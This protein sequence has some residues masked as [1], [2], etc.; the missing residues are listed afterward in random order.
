MKTLLGVVFILIAPFTILYAA[1][2]VDLGTIG[3]D[4]KVT[5]LE[6]DNSS[7]VVRFDI[8]GFTKIPVRIGT[9]TYYSIDLLG[10]S[11]SLNEGEPALPRICRSIIIPDDAKVSIKVLESEYIEFKST[12]VAP[13]KGNLY[14]DI[15]PD[16]IA[17]TFGPLYESNQWNP[18]E[19]AALRDP[20]I[21][22]D[23]RGTVIELYAFQYNHA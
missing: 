8:G 20:Y 14:R 16:D 15:N 10:E 1:Q 17:F 2:H 12:P 3:D 18:S 5:V 6:A 4:V 13:S 21:L 23:F 11:V 22:R 9:E 7:T 19:L